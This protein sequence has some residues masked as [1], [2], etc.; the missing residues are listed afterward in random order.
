MEDISI[1]W[2]ST[3]YFTAWLEFYFKCICSVLQC[4]MA[5]MLSCI[6]HILTCVKKYLPIYSGLLMFHILPAAF[7]FN[8]T[9]FNTQIHIVVCWLHAKGTNWNECHLTLP[10]HMVVLWAA[11]LS[12]LCLS[13]GQWQG[14]RPGEG[15]LWYDNASS[16]S[17][18][19][20]SMARRWGS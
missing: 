15:K 4:I 14:T 17:Y 6:S 20:N 16:S 7:F 13:I 2:I 18:L 10:T 3:V 11:Y 9:H 19:H 12:P 5:H 1:L 8:T